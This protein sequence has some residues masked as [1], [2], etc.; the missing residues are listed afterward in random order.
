MTQTYLSPLYGRTL[1]EFEIGA[2]YEHPWEVTVDVGHLAL[3]AGSFLDASP[4][5]ASARFARRLGFKDR[6]VHPLMLLNFGLSFSVHDVSEQAIAHLAYIEVRFPS[7][8]YAGDTL[9]AAST[10]LGVKRASEGERGVVHVRTVLVAEGPGGSVDTRVVCRF[11][12]KVLVKAGAPV[13]PAAGRPGVAVHAAA[14]HASADASSPVPH[15]PPELR[16]DRAL[17][18]A[19]ETAGL[20]FGGFFEDFAPGDVLCHDIGRT[21]SEAEH[22]QLTYMFRNSHPLHFEEPYARSGFAKTRVVYG[23]LVFGWVASL[24]SRDTSGNVLWELGYDKGAHPAG[25]IA[26]DTLYAASRVLRVEAVTPEMGAVTFRLVGTKNVK[27]AALLDGGADLF[28]E[29]LSKGGA[30]KVKEKVFEIERT[31][32]IRRRP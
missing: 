6:P 4:V 2:T 19:K 15:T 29:E 17:G 11:E 12:R 30:A 14:S 20:G 23:G 21:V 32:L 25:V 22:M 26:G 8:C 16:S 3:A 13:R 10:V 28:T 31:A 9:R 5:F 27:P 7:A 18:L 24:A 1:D